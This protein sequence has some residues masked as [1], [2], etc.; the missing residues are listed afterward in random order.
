MLS[1]LKEKDKVVTIG[2]LHGVITKV[3]ESTV[4]VKVDD[5][6]RLEFSR[7]AIS[8]VDPAPVKED[9]R[10]KIEKEEE[11]EDDSDKPEEQTE[12]KDEGESS[13]SGE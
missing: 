13:K 3:K 12:E 2:G 9:K 6:V 4:I 11:Q 1:A 7:S 8:S 10:E 5:N